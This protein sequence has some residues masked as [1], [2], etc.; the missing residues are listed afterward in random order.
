MYSKN[1]VVLTSGWWGWI[2]T[3]AIVAIRAFQV[4]AEPM[5][6]WSVVSWL[7]MTLPVLWPL[8][9]F[10]AA[11]TLYFLILIVEDVFSRKH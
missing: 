7:F 1:S 3:I 10:L 2:T 5:A 8:W 6:A 11:K 4:N 9:V